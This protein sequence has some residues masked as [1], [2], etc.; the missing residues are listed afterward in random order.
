M[1]GYRNCVYD[2]KLSRCIL[3]TWDDSGN[4]IKKSVDYTPYL[5]TETSLDKYDAVSI[6]GGRLKKRNFK[7]VFDRNQFVKQSG[8][9]DIYGN[10]SVTQQFLIDTYWKYNKLED[11]SKYPLKVFYIDIEVFSPNEFPSEDDAKFPINVITVYDSLNSIYRIF[12]LG[13][14]YKQEHIN[15]KNYIYEKYATEEE[16]LLAFIDYWKLDYPDI[17]TAWNLPFDIKYI[18]NRIKNLFGEEKVKEL[19][20]VKRFYSRSRKVKLQNQEYYKEQYVINGISLIDYLE[21]FDKFNITPMP[22]LRLDTVGEMVAN[23]PKL[24][25]DQDNLSDLAIHDWNR[26]VDYNI[27]DVEIILKIEEATNYLKVLRMLSYMG[28]TL[29]EQALGTVAVVTGYACVNAYEEN[30]IIPTFPEKKNWREYAGGFVKQPIVGRH[31]HIVSYDLNSLYPNAMITLNIS[32]ETKYGKIL[33]RNDNHIIIEN[34]NSKRYKISNENFLKFIKKEQIAIAKNDVL[35]SQKRRGIFSRMVEEVYNGRVDDKKRIKKLK[36]ELENSKDSITKKEI[37]DKISRLDIMQY[38]KKIYINSCYGALANKFAPMGDID[39]AEAITVTCQNVIQSSMI[40]IQDICKKI[41]QKYGKEIDNSEQ[42]IVYGDTDSQYISITKLVDIIEKPFL[43][44]N[45]LNP[46]YIN[47]V[48]DVI[49]KFLNKGMHRWAKDEL[50]SVDPRFEFK[51]E[52]ICDVAIFLDAKKVYVMH[53]LNSEGFDL[54]EE[55]QWKYVGGKLA[56]SST[57]NTLKKDIKKIIEN[58]IYTNDIYSTNEMYIKLYEKFLELGYDDIS[59]ISGMSNLTKWLDECKGFQKTKSG[60]PYQCKAAYYHNLLL[61]ELNLTSKYSKLKDGDKFKILDIDENN[62]FGIPTIAYL[63]TFPKEF[64]KYL[65]VN[66]LKRFDKG[67]KSIL[68]PFY[69]CMGYKISKP[70][71]QKESDIFEVFS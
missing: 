52:A 61:D 56:S 51:R 10:L 36:K 54:P 44:D 15:V 65:K 26:F 2:S 21:M 40:I 18:I 59:V 27:R 11:F 48:D 29:F 5:Y 19:S 50:N 71:M 68:E 49:E 46:F 34:T 67:V 47:L 69:K 58:L 8:I 33:E 17:V 24:K 62:K 53:V 3:F 37:E 13:K 63:N 32:P 25:F 55:K 6:F 23:M 1:V 41:A 38:S 22:N 4:R 12:G 9:N 7:N 60:M 35:F 64:E 42:M 28:C 14:D 43:V 45:K 31:K 16:L 57:P 70:N 30:K 66:K 39:L 20:P